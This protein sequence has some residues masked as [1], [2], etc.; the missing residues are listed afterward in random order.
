M[1]AHDMSVDIRIP[2]KLTKPRISIKSDI[3]QA[4]VNLAKSQ[5]ISKPDN[6]V[7][8]GHQ[9]LESINQSLCQMELIN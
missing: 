2:D 7:Q 9:R 5:F 6:K 8:I 1:T 4:P 3:S